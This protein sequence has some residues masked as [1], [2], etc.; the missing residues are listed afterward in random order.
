ML[1]VLLLIFLANS[2]SFKFKEKITSQTGND[3]AK[4]VE[5]AAVTAVNQVP[6]FS[7]NDTKL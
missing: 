5:I 7:I 1:T 6:I 3:V 4:D 2:A